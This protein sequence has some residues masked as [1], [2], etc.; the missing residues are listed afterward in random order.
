MGFLIASIV[1]ALSCVAITVK[2]LVGY[3]DF[4]KKTKL[5]IVLFFAL[6]WFAPF[7]LNLMSNVFPTSVYTFFYHILYTCFGFAFI[8]FSVLIIRD[9]IWYFVYWLAKGF[10]AGSWDFNPKNI[11][12]LGKANMIALVFAVLLSAYALVGGWA[13]P[14]I[15]KITYYTPKLA[16]DVNIVQISDVHINRT[17]PVSKVRSLV[18]QVNLLDPDIVI[19]TGDLVDDKVSEVTEQIEPLKD[20]KSKKGVYLSMGNHEYYNNIYEWNL[21]FRE[22]GI[23]FLFNQGVNFDDYKLFISGVPDLSI[24]THARDITIDFIKALKN[25]KPDYY[26]V[27]LSHTPEVIDFITKITFDAQFS[28]HTHGGQIFPF[29]VFVKK[30]CKYI[31]GQYRIND[32]E[33]Y[34]S[35]GAGQWGPMMRLFAPSEITKIELKKQ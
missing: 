19:I 23:K 10:G 4:S 8:L 14:E 13:E 2:T 20:L 3:S 33:L 34:V 35:R 28:G 30:V 26:K 32:V 27:L 21:K 1:V 5:L 12:V 18:R 22:L 16:Q 6:S 24:S 15:K 7:I 29:H 11:S 25:V 31:A 17:T 9:V